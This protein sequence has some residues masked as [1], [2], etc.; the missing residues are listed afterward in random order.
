MIPVVRIELGHLLVLCDGIRQLVVT[1]ELLDQRFSQF[2]IR[3]SQCDRPA[4][5]CCRFGCLILQRQRATQA[6]HRIDVFRM[7]LNPRFVIRDKP[8][9]IIP[10]AERCFNAAADFL[11]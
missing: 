5:P 6:S 8:R 11:K 2:D 4:I 7:T 3:R 10:A 9:K 1:D